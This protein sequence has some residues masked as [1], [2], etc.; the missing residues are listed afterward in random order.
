MTSGFVRIASA[1]ALAGV[2]W[3]WLALLVGSLTGI[4]MLEAGFVAGVASFTVGGAIFGTVATGFIVAGLQLK[5]FRRVVVGSIVVSFC[6]W[7]ILR[8]GGVALSTMDA[9]RYHVA[10]LETAQGFVL[11][12]CF[13]VIIGFLLRHQENKVDAPA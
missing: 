9:E 3:G 13:G 4:F 2:L 11:A 5:L 8:I 10:T 6:L 12:L 7:L 1:G